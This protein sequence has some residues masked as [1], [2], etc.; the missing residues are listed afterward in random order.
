MS[1]SDVVFESFLSLDIDPPY[2]ALVP[3]LKTARTALLEKRLWELGQM[4]ARL[5]GL[6]TRK[7]L[8]AIARNELCLLEVAKLAHKRKATVHLAPNGVV[9]FTENHKHRRTTLIPKRLIRISVS[10]I[11]LAQGI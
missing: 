10:K 8:D 11:R 9:I 3:A 1:D 4:A 2:A 5:H 6:N 7:A